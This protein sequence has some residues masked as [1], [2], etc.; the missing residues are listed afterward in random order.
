MLARELWKNPM[1]SK[2]YA[3]G[4]DH[5][6]FVLPTVPRNSQVSNVLTMVVR[7]VNNQA[8]C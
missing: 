6:S 2:T 5:N 1:N 8:L 3:L 4:P 7:V